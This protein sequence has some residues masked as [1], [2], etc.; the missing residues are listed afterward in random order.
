MEDQT[1][2][3]A[4]A[5]VLP[6]E[7]IKARLIDRYA[8]A[9]DASF[10]YLVPQVV[11]QPVGAGDIRSL[12]GVSQRLGIPMTFRA[13]GTSLSGQ[14]VTDGILVDLSRHWRFVQV[15][16]DGAMVRVQPGAIGGH[17]NTILRKYGRKIGP[18]PASINAAM[19]GGILSNNA[20]GMCCGVA[21]NAYHT[22]Q[23]MTMVLPNGLSFDTSIPTSYLRFEREAR[24]IHDGLLKIRQQVREDA[25]LVA[26]IRT[27]YRTKNTVGYGLNAFLDYEH[28]LDILA[29]LMI[30]AEGTLGFIAEAVLQTIPENP[31]KMTGMFYFEDAA[32][33]GKAIGI[34]KE[35]GAEALE[36]MDGKALRSIAHHADA[37]EIIRTLS[38]TNVAILCEYQAARVEALE[39]KFSAASPV[40]GQIQAIAQAPFT[41]DAREQAKLWKLR[42]GMYPS[43]AATR[44]SGEAIILED[45]TFPVERLGEAIPDLQA[46]FV[47]HGYQNGIIFGHAKDGNLHF[48]VSQS[49]HQSDVNRYADFMD[50]LVDLVLKKYD[51]ALKGEHGTGRNV[52][53]F[54]EAEWG[55]KA[56]TIMQ[57]VK[58]LLDPHGLLNPGV[59]LNADSTAHLKDLKA[60][61]V[62]EAEVD[63]CI[64][65]GFCENRCP[66]RDF[67][68]TP[69]QRIGIRRALKRLEAEGKH[70][71]V[72][73]INAEYKFDGLDTCAVDGLCALDCPVGINTGDLV[74]RL[75]RE[76]HSRFANRIAVASV[77]NFES[78]ITA[79]RM[80]VNSAH[81]MNVTLGNSTMT[82]VTR[83]VRKASP[84]FPQWSKQI[85]K[86]PELIGNTPPQ[87]DAVYFATCVN[88][89]MG[90][91]SKGKPS[92]METFLKVAKRAG[93]ELFLPTSIGRF[94]CGQIYGSKGFV[95]AQQEMANLTIEALWQWTEEGRMPVVLDVSSCTQSLR[96]LRP[97]LNGRNQR[98][99][100][101]MRIYDS[102]DYLADI[103]LPRLTIQRKK[104]KIVLHPVCSL[105][106][107]EL[108]EKFEAI[109]HACADEVV[110]PQ[111]AG[112]CGMAGDRGFL[113]PELIQSATAREGE[114]VR[115]AKADGCYASSRPCE[116]ALTE[117]IGTSYESILYL[118]EETSA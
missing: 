116:M 31:F 103:L 86:P 79:T 89:M 93:V 80:A 25:A 41:R 73:Q 26:R 64:E 68:L 85:T 92:V 18:D 13:A 42:K 54:V 81:K 115:K 6:P 59:I 52:A 53:P 30:G 39:A 47:E 112:C 4:L 60:L 24:N 96:S 117:A 95:Q 17:V 101:E 35:T 44:G 45:I 11:V 84:T 48:V 21:D 34:L 88:R 83:A 99:F 114:E 36:L 7:H 32:S 113:V 109:G 105:H 107:M 56:Y 111:H 57:Q 110:I 33:A 8:F 9:G 75:R 43:V 1:L 90:N 55:G 38:L 58:R 28:P 61:P 23:S 10:Y 72:H 76:R 97:F 29:H 82:H 3:E 50:D 2:L 78:F 70:Y 14:A 12:F 46:L 77:R 51:G 22:L 118:L 15:E 98:Y 106:K 63:K 49:L 66:S 94:C 62:V 27:K 67:T 100:D 69:R 40:F 71:E 87:A 65:C 108:V 16:E 102:V 5:Q 37:P 19:M 74:K 20:S 91:S 104:R